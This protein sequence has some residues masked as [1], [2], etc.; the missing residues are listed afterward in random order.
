M[1]IFHPY[2]GAGIGVA[3]VKDSIFTTNLGP[4]NSRS[5]SDLVSAKN[6]LAYR[7]T[8]GSAFALNE[9]I[10]L[11][12][13]YSYNDYGKTKSK[14]TARNIQLDKNHYKGH[15]LNVGFRFGL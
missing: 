10:K 7:L 1:S 13:A 4:N 2:L 5:H 12:I 15:L 8:L 11:D 9:N 3:G 14:I 6:N